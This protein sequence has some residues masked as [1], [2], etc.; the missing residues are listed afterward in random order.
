[1]LL[2]SDSHS[3]LSH[4]QVN[5]PHSHN[6]ETPAAI[7]RETIP[8]D[9]RGRV[10]RPAQKL[11]VALVSL[12]VTLFLVMAKLAVGLATGSLAIL[13]LA[14]ES[15]IDMASVVIT[16]LAVRVSSTPPDEDH[17][18]GHGKF[19]SV[20]ALGESV[21]LLAV[22]LWIAWQALTHLI[23]GQIREIDVTI[24]SFVVL[25]VSIGLDLW[26]SRLMHAAAREHHSHALE[27]SALHFLS[28]SLSAFVAIVGLVLVRYA[29]LPVADDIAAIVLAVFVASLAIRML[30]RSL[31]GLTD[32]F[33]SRNDTDRLLALVGKVPGVE[34]IARLRIRQAGP[35]LFVEVSI[36]V[37]R[38]LPYAAIE[39]VL[40][41]VEQAILAEFALAEVT[42]HWRPVRTESEAPFESLRL[43]VA[44]YGLQ[45]HNIELFETADGKVALDYHLEFPPGVALEEAHSLSE[46]IEK[47]IR[48][49]LPQIGPIAVHLE[50]QRSDLRL[51]RVEDIAA[52][53]GALSVGAQQRLTEIAASATAAAQGVRGLRDIHVYRDAD[54]AMQKLVL[55]ALV[56]PD[57]SLA[58]AHD[59]A[60]QVEQALKVKFPELTRVVIHA[61]PANG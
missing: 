49:E 30:R 47:H 3:S 42:V 59:I 22:T 9:Q 45:P 11:H 53:V 60:T 21:L 57:L 14:A 50:E 38:V 35:T 23:G 40:Q 27:S 8:S 7:T 26:R 52:S 15:G 43:I 37:S 1:M 33:T 19:E 46:K 39:R 2:R 54:G 20:A 18:Y 41:D 31:D 4:T 12:F 17:P 51:P 5:T 6:D 44:Q 28:D 56:A 34:S 32:R 61:E 25:V 13:S 55:T 48:E 58:Q 10:P 36:Q 16:L 24:W 29:G